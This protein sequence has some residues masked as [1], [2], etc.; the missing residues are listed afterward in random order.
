MYIYTDFDSYVSLFPFYECYH[1]VFKDYLCLIL[2]ILQVKVA[3]QCSN[4]EKHI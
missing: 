1:T 2:F 4:K 3:F